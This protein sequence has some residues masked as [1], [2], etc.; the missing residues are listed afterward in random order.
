MNKLVTNV[1]KR[2]QEPNT[3]ISSGSF[4]ETAP[5]T[6]TQ[7]TA[8]QAGVATAEIA[9]DDVQS[10]YE[11]FAE[12]TEEE[13]GNQGVEE[14][15]EADEITVPFRPERIK[16]RTGVNISI[17][18]IISRIQNEEIDLAPE[19]QRKA[20]I[21]KTQKR[22]RFIES[23]L[24]RIPIPVFY[25][26]SDKDENW[27]IVDGLQRITAI[28]SYMAG[29]FRL[30]KLEYLTQF[31]RLKYEDLPQPMQRR[32]NETQLV[33]NIIE[34]QTPEEVKFNIFHRINTGGVPLNR[35]E[36]RHA[37]Y[38]GPAL[39]YLEELADSSEFLQA[40]GGSVKKER[41]QDQELVLRFLAF[42][43]NS[44]AE[45]GAKSLDSYLCRALQQLNEMGD[46]ERAAL[47]S[48]FKKSM[49]VASSLFGERAF[50]KQSGSDSLR[51][52]IGL[53][54]INKPLFDVWSV[55]LASCTD[56]QIGLLES[57]KDEIERRFITLLDEDQEFQKAIT[58][59]TGDA[60]G[61]K[62]RFQTVADLLRE[63]L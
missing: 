57:R 4:A 39:E 56:E 28:N 35:Q 61:I 34:W 51:P 63:I 58:Y 43:K 47:A 49:R 60:A 46:G 41:M 50:R 42:H 30:Q 52:L 17:N 7:P 25:V 14:E 62:K 22:S 32:I 33:I 21:W 10:D 40:T 11:S 29:E 24:L 12:S 8:A 38:P 2:R 19:F 16:T 18:S 20:G 31:N 36:I 3:G 27:A 55:N 6:E 59:A 37:L 26:A 9:A 23:L 13:E 54:P 44:W 5:D 1:R 48:D 15:K 45:Y 53:R